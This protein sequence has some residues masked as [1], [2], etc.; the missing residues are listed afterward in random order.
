[1]IVDTNVLITAFDQ[2]GADA[3]PYLDLLFD[4]R[5]EQQL[6]VNEIVFAELSGRF[7]SA[8]KLAAA[9]SDLGVKITRL[10]LGECYRGGVAYREYRRR[11]GVRSTILPDFLIGAQAE[12]R[13]WPVLTSDRKGFSS[14]FP[15]VEIID[16]EAM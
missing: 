2:G 11:N 12:L 9:L 10:T 4:L 14:Y 6:H 5:D 13:G 7:P 8:E 16:P 15:T 1:M 3:A